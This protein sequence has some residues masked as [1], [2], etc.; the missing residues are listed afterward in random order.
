VT[1]KRIII[2]T[3]PGQDDA[4]AILVALASPDE[5]EVLLITTVAGNVPLD[6]TSENALKICELAGR[7]DVPVAAGCDR[8]LIRDLVTAEYVHGRTGLDGVHLPSPSLSLDPRNGVDLIIETVLAHEDVTLCAL[9]PLTNVATALLK[10]PRLIGRLRQIVLMG[11]G[12]FE[13]GN[14]TPAA[15]FNVYVDPEAAQHVL[16][17]GVP[18]VMMPLDVTHRAITTPDFVNRL[19][20]LRTPVG[21]ATAGMLEFYERYDRDRYG[22]EGA[23]LHDPCVIS[24]LIAPDLFSGR[25]CNVEVETSSE[26]TRGMTVIDWWGMTNRRR[27]AMVMNR[28]DSSGYFDLIVRRLAAINRSDG[29]T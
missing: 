1:P 16:R 22:L 20:R 6:L 7:S 11:G 21:E 17:S 26:L 28:I 29:R 13:G 15:E 10:E 3:D 9:G 2:D 18:I 8:P 24:Y 5:L 23:P 25:E 19:K 12:F 4:F 27:N 14:T